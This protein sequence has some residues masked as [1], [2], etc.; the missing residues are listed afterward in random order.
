MKT[1]K[2]DHITSTVSMPI[3]AGTIDFLQVAWK[4]IALKLATFAGSNVMEIA[5]SGTAIWGLEN[6]DSFPNYDIRPGLIYFGGELYICD[7]ATF[8]AS[9]GQTA[10]CSIVTTYQTA[11]DADPVL[12]TDGNSYNVHEIKK[13]N[14]S[15]GTS[16]TGAFDYSTLTFINPAHNNKVQTGFHANWLGS[17]LSYR[18]NANGLITLTGKLVAGASASYSDL[19]C[20][21]P[22]GWRPA[23]DLIVSV[24]KFDGTTQLSALVTIKANGQV[25]IYHTNGGVTVSDNYYLDTVSFY[26]SF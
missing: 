20:T 22:T 1:L 14:V 9:V 19:I 5:S 7:G 2:T 16:G 6:T 26:K 4:E 18:R 23:A 15:A 12:F 3:K 24:S 21:L 11:S 17:A 10:I 13:I 8:T 25:F